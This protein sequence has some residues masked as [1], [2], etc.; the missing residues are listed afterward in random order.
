[1]NSIYG[2]TPACLAAGSPCLKATPSQFHGAAK[3]F[4]FLFFA[5]LFPVKPR[6]TMRLLALPFVLLLFVSLLGE[7][8]FSRGM[9]FYNMALYYPL[10][11]ILAPWAGWLLLCEAKNGN[12]YCRIA[13]V[14]VFVVCPLGLFDG[15]WFYYRLFSWN[16]YRVRRVHRAHSAGGQE[17]AALSDC[18]RQPACGRGARG[19]DT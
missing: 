5:E 9:I 2:A 11:A 12:A 3:I 4:A 17:S 15:L 18:M 16:M 7:I 8:I 10:V 13:L 1:M 14:P 6:R 19:G